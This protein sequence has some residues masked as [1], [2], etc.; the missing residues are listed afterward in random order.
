VKILL[1]SPDTSKSGSEAR[2][3]DIFTALREIP[4]AGHPTIGSAVFVRHHLLPGTGTGTE[5]V[6]ALVTKAGRIELEPLASLPR[7]IQAKIPHDGESLGLSLSFIAKIQWSVGRRCVC[8][9]RATSS[10]GDVL[11]IQV[12]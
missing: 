9:Y 7:G 12:I 3:I 8:V 6:R 1:L 5:A 2:D 10:S 11:H 4:F